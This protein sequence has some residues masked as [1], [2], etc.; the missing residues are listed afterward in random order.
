MA[1]TLDENHLIR[2]IYSLKFLVNMNDFLII[3]L[4]FGLTGN[5]FGLVES[6]IKISF[7]MLTFKIRMFSLKSFKKKKNPHFKSLT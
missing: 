3:C 4:T 7:G 6:I 5:N 1:F 2:D